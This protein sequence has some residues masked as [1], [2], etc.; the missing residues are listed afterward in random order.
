LFNDIFDEDED[1]EEYEIVPIHAEAFFSVSKTGEIHQRLIFDYDDPDEYYYS[2]IDDE[3]KLADELGKVSAN[4]QDFLDDETVIINKIKVRPKVI[5]CD[6][7]HRGKPEIPSITFVIEFKGTF[8]EGKNLI[9]T[10]TDEE[11]APYDF[12][13]VWKFP[14]G[15]EIIDVDTPLHY[16]IDGTILY[17]WAYE[18]EKVGGREK[19]AFSLK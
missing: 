18:G 7:I 2:I 11:Y 15:S 6:I 19:I 5:F 14:E 10:Y 4:M 3:M 9:D 13:V 12:E 8:F 1:D 16:E 17:L